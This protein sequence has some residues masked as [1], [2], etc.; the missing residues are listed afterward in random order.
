MEYDF[1]AKTTVKSNHYFG[2]SLGANFRNVLSAPR[3]A[4]YKS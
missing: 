4:Y 1:S 2:R 3:H